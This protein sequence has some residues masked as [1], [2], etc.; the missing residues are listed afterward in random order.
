MA[1]KYIAPIH[2]NEYSIVF[3]SME[4]IVCNHAF[5][6][7]PQSILHVVPHLVVEIT[8]A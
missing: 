1:K 4:I 3:F 5:S 7:D 2:L 8:Y 6:E